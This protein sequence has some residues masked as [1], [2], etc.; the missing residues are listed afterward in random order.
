MFFF[1]IIKYPD[2]RAGADID[3]VCWKL[4]EIKL[5]FKVREVNK[6]KFKMC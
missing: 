3:S 4:A 6:D 2:M 5:D 1:L